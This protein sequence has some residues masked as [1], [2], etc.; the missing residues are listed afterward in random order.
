MILIISLISSLKINNA[1]PFLALTAPFPLTFL[2]NFLIAFEAKLL[3]NPGKISIA[4]G[5]AKSVIT[6]FPMLPKILQINPPE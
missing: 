2:S 5:K 6:F 3:T 4:Q 1:N